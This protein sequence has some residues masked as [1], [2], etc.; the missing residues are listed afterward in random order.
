MTQ[1]AGARVWGCQ[2]EA[3]AQLCP[4]SPV[5]VGCLGDLLVE[6][7]AIPILEV[8]PVVMLDPRLC[9]VPEGCRGLVQLHGQP[10]SSFSL[11]HSVGAA[12]GG[13]GSVSG[14]GNLPWAG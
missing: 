8:T 6:Q 5:A 1:E 4:P 2:A 14:E 9:S 3:G 11:N 13:K 7:A 12:R 10:D